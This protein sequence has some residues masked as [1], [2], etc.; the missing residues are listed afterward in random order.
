MKSLQKP[1]LLNRYSDSS[2]CYQHSNSCYREIHN[3]GEMIKKIIKVISVFLKPVIMET[4]FEALKLYRDTLKFYGEDD[5]T[6]IKQYFFGQS[7]VGL[8]SQFCM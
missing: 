4:I 5:K 8:H 7:I 1:L 6:N 3:E 2:L